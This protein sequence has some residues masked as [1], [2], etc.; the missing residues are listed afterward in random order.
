MG[1]FSANT[2]FPITADDTERRHRREKKDALLHELFL[3][4]KK[5]ARLDRCRVLQPN[6]KRLH[7]T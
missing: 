3:S 4:L 7:E 6:K 5:L 1:A 2:L